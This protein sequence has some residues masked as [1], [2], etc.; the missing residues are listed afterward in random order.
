[1]DVGTSGVAP[2]HCVVADDAA[3]WMVQGPQDWVAGVLG[4]IEAGCLLL[5]LLGI[6]D[7]RI[8]AL[9]LVDLGAPMHGP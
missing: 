6:D 3:G 8:D 4:D 2:H 1:M 5:D 7:A 9:Q